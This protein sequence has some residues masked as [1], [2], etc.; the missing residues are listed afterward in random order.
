[1]SL[2]GIVATANGVA[3]DLAAE[4]GPAIGHALSIG[5]EAT[6]AVD[7]VVR[8]LGEPL[9][10]PTARLT[11]A[12]PSHGSFDG[13]AEF[14][15]LVLVEAAP[16]RWVPDRTVTWVRAPSVPADASTRFVLRVADGAWQSGL[17]STTWYW[18]ANADAFD[19][20]AAWPGDWE[21]DQPGLDADT[22]WRRWSAAARTWL[23][24]TG[25]AHATPDDW[26]DIRYRPGAHTTL[27]SPAAGP[28][29]AALRVVHAW[30]AET[31]TTGEGMDGGSLDWVAPDGT[32]RPAV[33]V[34]GWPARL[35]G[36][37]DMAL[38]GRG[39]F[40]GAMD[41]VGDAPVWRV[42]VVNVPTDA[43]GPW[44]LRFSFA[45]NGLFS[46]H[47]G[48][49]VAEVRALAE[50]VLGAA[51]PIGWDGRELT[52]DVP[53]DWTAPG[54][55]E[56]LEEGNWRFFAAGTPGAVAGTAGAVLSGF[57]GRD[58][59]RQVVRVVAPAGAGP[60]AT[61]DVVIYPDGGEAE[62][63]F[64]GLPWPNPA[65]NEV[66][67][68][69]EVPDGQRARLRIFDLRGRLLREESH[70]AGSHLLSWDGTQRNGRRVA[71]GTYFLQVEGPA[72]SRTHKVVFL[73]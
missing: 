64:L 22:T 14:V 70:P 54:E 71:S 73:H 55:V 40:A 66:R 29:I 68:L 49:L 44:R 58:R 31:L 7:L 43:P 16:G 15:D 8:S 63:P 17:R 41:L 5:P 59:M 36:T 60:T 18:S 53:P 46:N 3:A 20:T 33:P 45:S 9:A 52:W 28:G 11:A 24:C 50:P 67:F 37:S 38:H 48:W 62:S 19:F 47:R 35:S 61:R 39:G 27:T 32:V 26:P 4:D 13:V 1:V 23:V 21:I 72:G 34:D 57:P 12:V 6:A 56:I 2:T 10:A 25:S 42:D 51:I 69:L 65:R 30:D